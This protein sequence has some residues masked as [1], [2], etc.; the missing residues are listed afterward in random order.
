[1]KNMKKWTYFVVGLLILGSF[2]AISLGEAGIKQ[3][4]IV[5]QQITE[6]L[7]FAEPQFED[8]IVDEETYVQVSIEGAPGSLYQRVRQ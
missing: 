4:T 3:E 1:M 2:T 5:D 8:K 6:T 7:L